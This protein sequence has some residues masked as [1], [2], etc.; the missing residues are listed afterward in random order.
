MLLLLLLLLLPLLHAQL[1]VCV[2]ACVHG[3]QLIVRLLHCTHSAAAAAAAV[4]AAAASLLLLC[5]SSR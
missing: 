4:A 3:V 1:S 5:G 2:L